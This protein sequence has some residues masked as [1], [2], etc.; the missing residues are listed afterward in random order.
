MRSAVV[1]AVHSSEAR[2]LKRFSFS[3]KRVLG[4]REAR[5][6]VCEAQLGLARLA[7]SRAHSAEERTRAHAETSR[8]R[9]RLALGQ[10]FS[11]GDTGWEA[12]R[13]FI[14]GLLAAAQGAQAAAAAREVARRQNELLSARRERKMLEKIEERRLAEHVFLAGREEAREVEDTY[15]MRREVI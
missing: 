6:R 9:L 7:L 13:I 1:P 2:K 5:E 15:R 11:A 14:L 3:L 12:E 8:Q 4:V 10:R